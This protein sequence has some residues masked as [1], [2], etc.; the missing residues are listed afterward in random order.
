MAEISSKSIDAFPLNMEASKIKY[1]VIGP[2]LTSILPCV[3]ILLMRTTINLDDDVLPL[4]KEYAES[5]SVG[6]GKALSE[7]VRRG[8]NAPR[9]TRLVNGLQ[10]FDLPPDSPPVTTK[11][12]RKLEAEE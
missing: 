6:M 8:I 9:P 11:A 12:V 2:S 7:L 4:V 1:D 10:V 3:I 5:R